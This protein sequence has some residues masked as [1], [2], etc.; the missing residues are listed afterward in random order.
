[1]SQIDSPLVTFQLSSS[2]MGTECDLLSLVPRPFIQRMYRFQY[3]VRKSPRVILKAIRA[4]VGWAGT[5]T[6]S[7]CVSLLDRGVA[8][9][10][11]PR[12]QAAHAEIFKLINYS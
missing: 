10:W 11:R 2:E 3:N 8:R 7:S 9:I 12:R 5:E 6:T 4:G 1:M